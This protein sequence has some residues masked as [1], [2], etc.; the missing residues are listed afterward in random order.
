MGLERSGHY[1]Y[2]DF[3]IEHIMI[4]KEDSEAYDVTNIMVR[5]E[6]IESIEEGFMSGTLSIMDSMGLIDAMKFD[7][8]EVIGISFFSNRQQGGEAARFSNTFAVT[9]YEYMDEQ[10][11]QTKGFIRIHFVSYPEIENEYH[12]VSKSYVNTGVHQIITD[13]LTIIGVPEQHMD[14]EPTLYNKDIVIPNLTPL[15]VIAYISKFAHSG[16]SESKGDTNFYFFENRD[17]I[18]F[19]SGSTLF[20]QEPVF[21][22]ISEATFDYGMYDKVDKM[23]RPR[24]HNLMEQVRNGGLGSTVHSFSLLNKN[25]KSVFMEADAVKEVYSRLNVDTWYGGTKEGIRNACHEFVSEDQ[26]YKFLNMGS[27][28]NAMAIRNVNRVGASAKRLLAVVAGNTD[29]TSGDIIEMVSVKSEDRAA[30]NTD[31]GLWLVK[32]IIHVLDQ[33]S[34]QMSLD[35]ISDSNARTAL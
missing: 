18:R 4:G 35:L 3:S 15:E 23:I 21:R 31:T 7:G 8:N 29:V 6:I 30:T 11:S 2:A 14:I 10:Q 24:G 34:Y 22:Y 33:S 17:S 19:V 5:L 12:R 16:K 25:Y 32:G 13:M 9:R 28:G 27:N 20:A 26:M 1:A